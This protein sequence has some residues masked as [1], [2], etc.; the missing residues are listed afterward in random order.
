[1]Y[2]M[3]NR[4]YGKGELVLVYDK[5][6]DNQMSGKGALRWRGP[7]A[8]VARRPSGAYVLQELD[9]AMLRQLIAWKQLKSYVP[10]QGLE[11]AI[12]PSEWISHVDEIKEDL[13][14]N[15]SNELQ[16]LM[17]HAN[18]GC[19]D[20]PSLPKPWL[21]KDEEVNEYWQRVYQKW[22]DRQEKQKARIQLE[23]ELEISKEMQ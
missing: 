16:V 1:M 22:M 15:N 12:L 19:M 8:I 4:D 14:K 5:A 20:V 13:L 9:G 3:K 7:Y 21:L 6:L 18:G 11:L 2:G 23:P 17:V 10:R